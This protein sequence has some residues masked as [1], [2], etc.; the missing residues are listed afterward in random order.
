MS[1]S[2][3]PRWKFTDSCGHPRAPKTIHVG[4][5]SSDH[6][7]GYHRTRREFFNTGI[8]IAGAAGFGMILD[9]REALA[10]GR[11]FP[12]PP[13]AV[14]PIAGLMDTHVHTAPDVFGRALDDVE[15]AGLYKERGL[16]ALVLKNHVATTADRA[17][18]ARKHVEGLKVFG[19]IVLNSAVGGI[20]PDA[21]S[22]M[23][24]MQGGF[25]RVVWF[26][27]FDADN[28]VKHFK[29]AP[30]GVKIVDAQGEVLPEVR[31]VLKIAAEQ[32]LVVQT[33]HISPTEALAVIA[34]GRDMGVDRIVVT[35]A[36]FE[37]VNMSLKQMKQ[38][39][40]MG[41]KLELC[42]MGAL[43]GP[44][45]HYEWMRHWE[46]KIRETAA[47]IEEIGAQNFILAT[48][49]GQA[50]NPTPPDGLQ[51]FVIDL[52]KVGIGKDEIIKMGREVTGQL[53]MG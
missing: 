37:V 48:D 29:D 52:M 53:L 16:D 35:H 26:P 17:W 21:V 5:C 8:S 12:P 3:L 2:Y 28:H 33:G 43:M 42:A 25:G 41:A 45:A 14:S 51:F 19:G 11:V 46:V 4:G 20:N 6:V 44:A 39:A 32:K 50:G 7:P 47:A 36:Q 30:E 1:M 10:Q 24:R 27:T 40:S 22:W 38:A 18:F 34:A 23:W 13:P 9:P 49:L 31:R 15:L